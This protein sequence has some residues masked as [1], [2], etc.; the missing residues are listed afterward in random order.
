MIRNRDALATSDRHDL[1]LA[2]VERGIEAAHPRTVIGESVSLEDGT[3]AVA[4]ERYDLDEYEEVIVLGGGKAAA[5]VAAA[6]ESVLGDR[7]S[8]G[9]VVT[10]DPTDTDV[11][12]VLEGSHPLPDERTVRGTERVLDAAGR[13]DED[14]L[15]LAAITGGG[16]ALLTAPA[17]PLDALRSVTEALLESGATIH[18][19]NAV[20]KHLSRIKGGHL[21]RTA[22][23]ATVVALVLSDVV[24]DD[25]EVIASGPTVPDG[26]TFAD[27]RAVLDRHGIELPAAV[28]EHLDRGARG[29]VA[30]T[31][32]E[33]DPAFERASVHVLADGFTAAA[34]ARDAARERGYDP[35]ILSTRVRGEASAAATTHVAVAEEIRA[36]GN[37]LSPPAVVISGGE[38]TVSVE[39]D[40]TGGPNQEFALAGALEIDD[41]R[42]VLA[43]VDTDGI[44]GPTD[45]AG[46]VVD[47]DAVSDAAAA[48]SALAENDAYAHLDARDALV[49]TG[50]TGTNV[51]DLRVLVVG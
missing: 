50:P 39:G 28:R 8:G 1:A 35:C 25:P 26:T 6:L 45:A 47:A 7:L 17:V 13:A 46:G 3:L 34:A 30:E 18:E 51:N 5:Q 9:A 36:T 49:R 29:E 44:D 16:S 33:D 19:I 24:G 41:G 22:V 43:S 14:T 32:T 15:V 4:G 27:A 48:R 11:V 31:P 10:Y 42:T 21:A 37:P 38:T 40:G 2:C 12:D 20:R 23:P